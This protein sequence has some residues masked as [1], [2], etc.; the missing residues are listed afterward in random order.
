MRP[1]PSSAVETGPRRRRVVWAVLTLALSLAALGVSATGAIFTETDDHAANTFATGSV[2]FTQDDG[3]APETVTFAASNMAPGDTAT[4]TVNVANTGSLALRYAMTSTT[5]ADDLAAQLTMWVWDEADEN[6]LLIA[7]IGVENTTCDATPGANVSSYVY[8]RGVLGSTGGTN[9]IGDIA[10][11]ADT[12]DREL[13]RCE[14]GPVLPRRA[15]LQHRQ[16]LRGEDGDRH[17]QLPG[18]AG[19]EQRLTSPRRGDP[20]PAR[21][22][23]RPHVMV[24]HRTRRSRPPTSEGV[25]FVAGRRPAPVVPSPPS[26][27]PAAVPVAGETPTPRRPRGRLRALLGW[28]GLVVA[29]PVVVG[30]IALA[31]LPSFDMRLLVVLSGSMEPTIDT[32]DAV[33]VR[34]ADPA[35]V[36]IGDVITFHGYGAERLTTH[37]VI[38]V[39]DVD[40]NR[41]FRTQGDANETPDPNLAPAGG[42]V[43]RVVLRLPRF[44]W[45]ALQ[46]QRPQVRLVALA[47]PALLVAIGA[48]RDLWGALRSSP[49]AGVR[50]AATPRRGPA[51]GVR[52]RRR[53]WPWRLASPRSAWGCS[54]RRRAWPPTSTSTRRAATRSR[55]WPCHRPRA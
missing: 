34:T 3:T 53:A 25:L 45:V 15:A 31:A 13:R 9:V 30:M 55:R 40:G 29:V 41:H 28:M 36:G 12:G 47:L 10:Q 6:D 26:P 49:S 16:H 21:A 50:P 11:G 52:R 20:D 39:R 19:R 44:G 51:A 35:T 27:G 43:G 18:R 17:V 5:L 1:S 48:V 8:T 2:D 22:G 24:R 14:R 54:G 23:R 42:V 33:V 4:D 7:G 37:R 32:G 46:L 38:D